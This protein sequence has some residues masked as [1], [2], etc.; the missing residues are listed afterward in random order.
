MNL[1][2]IIAYLTDLKTHSIMHATFD[3]SALL[4]ALQA[5]VS[6]D[7]PRGSTTNPGNYVDG[8]EF[9]EQ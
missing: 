3:T 7:K 8:G 2:E 5:H 6:N 1:D 9:G 4:D